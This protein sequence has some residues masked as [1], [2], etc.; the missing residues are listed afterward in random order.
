MMARPVLLFSGQWADLPLEELAPKASEWGY[1]GLELSCWGD[2]FEVQ[3]AL[4]EEGYCQEKLDLLTRYDLA[5]PVLAGHRVGQAV[6]DRIDARHQAMLPDYVWGDGDPEGV[7][8]R[9]AEEMMAIARG[10]QKLGVGVLSGFT[11]SALWSYVMGYPGADSTVVAEGFKD[12]SER[13]S[14]ILDVCREC[15]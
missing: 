14:P 6:C 15:G 5:V 1:Q 10:A 11:G 7:R 2:H 8:Q 3:R 13:W 4:S 12:F 9:A